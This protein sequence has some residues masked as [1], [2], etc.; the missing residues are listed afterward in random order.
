MATAGVPRG[1]HRGR[2]HRPTAVRAAAAI[3][4]ADGISSASSGGLYG[5][6]RS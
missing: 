2:G 3:L 4:S 1:I 6:S 5:I